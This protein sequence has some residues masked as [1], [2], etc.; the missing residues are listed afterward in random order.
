[1]I[2]LLIATV[3]IL[4][5]QSILFTAFAFQRLSYER[6]FDR[7]A[8][9]AGDE[10]GLIETITNRKFLPLP[11]VIL[12]STMHSSLRFHSSRN[13]KISEGM[14]YQYHRSFFSILPYMQIRRKHRI[15][16][17]KRGC[18]R[19]NSVSITTG[20]PLGFHKVSRS[21]HLNVELLVYPEILDAGELPVPTRWMGEMATDRWTTE[22]P[23]LISGTRE[24]RFGDPLHQI[25]WKATAR[26]GELQVFNRE[27]TA[28][29]TLMV[30]VNFDIS[31]K[32]WE[33]VTDPERI[34]RALQYAASYA[35]HLI[36][37][38]GAVGFGCNGID[39]D[40]HQDIVYVPAGRGQSHLL[41]IYE[42]IARLLIERSDRFD[43]FL[44]QEVLREPENTDYILLTSFVNEKIEESIEALRERGNRVSIVWLKEEKKEDRDDATEQNAS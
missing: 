41:Q 5:L 24:Y 30:F 31:D 33:A 34:E 25:H 23:Y 11:W 8:C 40:R 6:T 9:F 39:I 12:E 14:M 10:V 18:F 29:Q 32:M 42:T 22:D 37:S 21:L 2:W 38:G 4:V 44:R 36:Q 1:M 17:T 15:T 26:T 3:A 20:D 7:K 28:D 35:A 16:C 13:L 27:H 19:L 43:A